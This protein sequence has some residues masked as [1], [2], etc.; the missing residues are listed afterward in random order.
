MNKIFNTL[1]NMSPL[2]YIG[3][4]WVICASL[5]G[6]TT[7]MLYIVLSNVCLVGS[8]LHHRI[9]D[10]VQDKEESQPNKES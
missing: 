9:E 4:F 7:S 3:I 10:L 8:Y 6:G 5:S 1:C 2:W